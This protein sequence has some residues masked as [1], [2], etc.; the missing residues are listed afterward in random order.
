MLYK[1]GKRMRDFFFFWGGGAFYLY[2]SL[3]FYRLRAFLIINNYST[4]A[5]WI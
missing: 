4:S 2:F 5:R 1:Y 3:V